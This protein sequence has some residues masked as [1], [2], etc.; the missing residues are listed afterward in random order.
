MEDLRNPNI[1]KADLHAGDKVFKRL[2]QKMLEKIEV[3][4]KEPEEVV[5]MQSDEI[6]DRET[7]EYDMDKAYFYIILTGTFKVSGPRFSSAKK[8][9]MSQ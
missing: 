8:P 4:H 2:V 6:L 5:I 7:G 3:Q 1:E 9:E